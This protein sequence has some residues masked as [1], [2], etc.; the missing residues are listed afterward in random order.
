[1]PFRLEGQAMG[2]NGLS[3]D[4]KLGLEKIR[5][6]FPVNHMELSRQ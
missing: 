1:M 6:F 4:G 3:S 2:W 5:T